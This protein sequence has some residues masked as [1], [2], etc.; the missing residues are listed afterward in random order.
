MPLDLAIFRFINVT[1]AN[2]VFDFILGQIGNTRL[3]SFP[4]VIIIILLLWKGGPRGRWLVVLSL[5]TV[6]VVDSS[7]HYIW[8]PLFGRL[9]PC[10]AEPAITWLRLIQGCGGKYGLPSSHAANLFS[11][12]VVIGAFYKSSRYYM[13]PLAIVISISRIYL[14]VHYPSDVLAGALYGALIGIVILYLAKAIAP[15]K[16]SEF[17][18]F[19][20]INDAN[21]KM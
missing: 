5:L 1:A 16:L 13:Y 4:I 19:K 8:K 20:R 2:P 9:R 18:S 10:H 3:L 12:A 21:H 11:Q 15:N 6:G 17:Y 7:I 14:G